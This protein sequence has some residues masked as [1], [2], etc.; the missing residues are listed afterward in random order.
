MSAGREGG[1]RAAVR[2]L[3]GLSPALASRRPS[4]GLNAP[5]G[6]RSAL[7]FVVLFAGARSW[8]P[9]RPIWSR[10]DAVAAANPGRPLVV[11]HGDCPDG[12]DQLVAVWARR[13]AA[14]GWDVAADPHPA[15]WDNCGPGCPSVPHR[16]IKRDGDS[17]HP[18][19]LGDYCPT[20]GPR[21][22][23]LMVDLGADL[24][25]AAPLGASYGTRGCMKLA[26]SA[27]IPIEDLS[28]AAR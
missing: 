24:M 5:Q 25:L 3:E 8:T 6:P 4:G 14:A 26:R 22:N 12:A 23:R 9:P 1:E 10:L 18:G 17:A 7:P 28:K 27:G 20:A 16:K 2:P 15:D 11:R 19:Q 21:R 13:A